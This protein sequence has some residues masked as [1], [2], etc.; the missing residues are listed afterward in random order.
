MQKLVHTEKL[1]PSKNENEYNT[2]YNISK[3]VSVIVS[4]KPVPVPFFDWRRVLIAS[5]PEWQDAWITYMTESENS[6]RC[7]SYEM[8]E[9]EYYRRKYNM[10]SL[11]CMQFRDQGIKTYMQEA[12]N[13]LRLKT[14]DKRFEK[15][16]SF[17]VWNTARNCGDISVGEYT[18]RQGMIMTDAWLFIK[19]SVVNDKI[20]LICEHD[21]E[22]WEYKIGYFLPDALKIQKVTVDW[23]DIEFKQHRG[24][25]FFDAEDATVVVDYYTNLDVCENDCMEFESVFWS[26]PILYA[27]Y[28]VWVNM[29]DERRFEWFNEYERLVKSYKQYLKYSANDRKPFKSDFD[30]PRRYQSHAKPYNTFSFER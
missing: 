15:Q 13:M 5:V 12:I 30:T 17:N 24:Y 20:E 19:Y 26:I 7:L 28:S 16:Y 6:C 4:G 9:M 29:T 21:T 23:Q 8:L 25:F 10:E 3:V 14:R 27:L 18:P 11:D 2:L 1:I 22:I